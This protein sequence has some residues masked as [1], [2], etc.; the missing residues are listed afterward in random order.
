MP[1]TETDFLKG[2]IDPQDKLHHSSMKALEEI[3]KRRWHVASSAFI[4]LDLLLKKNSGASIGDRIMIFQA[5]K[6][7]IPKE[8]I[9]A[10]SPQT[11]SQA[12]LLQSKYHKISRFYFD[13]IHLAIATGLD[14]EIV[15]SDKTFDQ[16]EEIKRIPLE[17]L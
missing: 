11:L 1:V 10:V 9:L 8:T 16:V 14:D 7:E 4:E 15:S 5:L 3:K 17:K 2:I 6:S 13:S 12:A